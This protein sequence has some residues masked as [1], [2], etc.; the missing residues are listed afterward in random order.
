MHFNKFNKLP[1][2]NELSILETRIKS[3]QSARFLG[4]YFD[5]D[6]SFKTHISKVIQKC[7]QALNIVKFLRGT[8]WGSDPSTLLSFY[9][10][11]VRS[12][13]DYGCFIY[14]PVNKA[15]Q[16]KLER[17]QNHAIRLC[18]GYRNSTPINILLG[19]SKL[20]R[21][22][23]RTKLL[24][25]KFLLKSI[26]NLSSSLYHIIENIFLNLLLILEKKSLFLMNVSQIFIHIKISFYLLKNLLFTLT[27][28]KLSPLFLKLTHALVL[29]LTLIIIM[30]QLI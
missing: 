20:T 3:V 21:I 2:E 29:K 15:S 22:V 12:I 4:I 5:F 7:N 25:N 26:T 13:I 8:W 28:F 30:K 23:D 24:C 6:M 1:G 11:Y 17:I 16:G 27:P 10:S 9:K 19:E 14:F 18:M